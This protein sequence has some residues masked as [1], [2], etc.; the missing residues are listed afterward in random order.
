MTPPS[1]NANAVSVVMGSALGTCIFRTRT[2]QT[3]T[4]IAK[5]VKANTCCSPMKLKRI[6]PS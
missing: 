5:S 2:A 1:T 3:M 6:C 4:A